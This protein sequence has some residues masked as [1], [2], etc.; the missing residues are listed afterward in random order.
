MI[1]LI[2]TPDG[3][4]YDIHVPEDSGY[5]RAFPNMNRF[6]GLLC[7]KPTT[8][9]LTITCSSVKDLLDQLATSGI[10]LKREKDITNLIRDW[11]IAEAY[12]DGVRMKYDLFF[13]VTTYS[14]TAGIQSL[15]NN[16]T[17]SKH[18]WYMGGFHDLEGKDTAQAIDDIKYS[19]LTYIKTDSLDDVLDRMEQLNK[20]RNPSRSGFFNRDE[21]RSNEY[22]K[23]KVNSIESDP[24][25]A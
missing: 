18:G 24:T 10:T 15:N 23:T 4:Y 14:I 13:I 25:F 11:Q 1:T 20:L 17:Y 22:F 3:R 7:V 12:S 6:L 21:V 2:F 8:P 19:N 16:Y 9:T 5:H